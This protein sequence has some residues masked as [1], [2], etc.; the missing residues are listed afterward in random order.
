M[1]VNL[2]GLVIS[3]Y[4]LINPLTWEYLKPI[5]RV[6]KTAWVIFIYTPRGNNHGKELYD[7]A[8]ANPDTWHS[9][10]LTIEDTG[11]LTED[12]ITQEIAE[13]M[14]W[15]MAQQEYYCS[16]EAGV[17]GSY[18]G[19]ALAM[20]RKEDRVVANLP[21]EPG[22]PIHTFWDIGIGDA[23]A[24]WFAQFISDKEIRMVD[25]Y[26][27]S[28]EGLAHYHGI[29]QQKALERNFVYDGHFGPH[30][31]ESREFGTGLTRIEQAR[32]IGLKFNVV[33]KLTVDEGIEMARSVFPK[34]WFD[35]KYCKFG[36][37][38]LENYRK[39]YNEKTKAYDK[40]PLH[41]WSS[42]GSDAF[43]YMAVSYK[44]LTTLERRRE[45]KNK[46]LGV[47]VKQY[48]TADPLRSAKSRTYQTRRN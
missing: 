15:E 43:R 13:G 21:L 8:L 45:N 47:R 23:T 27:N 2:K 17:P 3:E 29:L 11:V 5:F 9:S 38:A 10:L 24:I 33:A 30:D 34:V 25:Y 44:T 4:S 16:F 31:I 7:I 41:D 42:N 39:K 35:A 1:G 14:S 36:L 26:E 18:Y 40:K 37:S 6:N 48:K 19:R 46:R 22:V 12:D 28:G 32:E 20:A